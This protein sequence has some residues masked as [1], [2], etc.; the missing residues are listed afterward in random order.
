MSTTR[1][2]DT[3]DWASGGIILEPPVAKQGVGWEL[4]EFPPFNFVNWFWNRS[5]IWVQHFASVASR[6]ETIEGAIE[7]GPASPF[8]LDG[9]CLVKG[10][11]AFTPGSVHTVDVTNLGAAAQVIAA[12]G[13][14]VVMQPGDP[15]GGAV[16]ADVRSFRRDGS[17]TVIA[18]YQIAATATVRILADGVHVAYPQNNDLHVY[19]HD[20]GANL[21][22]QALGGGTI[23]DIAWDDGFI[24]VVGTFGGAQI[25]K[26]NR[27]TGVT[28]W[29][30][31]H[32]AALESVAVYGDRVF[33]AGVASAHASGATIRSV[34]ASDGFDTTGEGGNGTD[35]NQWNAVQG[36]LT[37]LPRML[38]VDGRGLYVGAGAAV[39][40]RSPAGGEVINTISAPFGNDIRSIKIDHARLFAATSDRVFPVGSGALHVFDRDTLAQVWRYLQV[41]N[42]RVHDIATDGDA[43]FVAQIIGNNVVPRLYRGT[44]TSWW[45]RVDPSSAS[46]RTVGALRQLLIPIS[47]T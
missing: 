14:S 21:F 4:R 37:T 35:N 10:D 41:G 7:I 11:E 16:A 32:N 23:N 5:A 3:P 19:D 9:T 31:D 12:T 17:G 15:D 38:A 6:F 47:R 2:T 33:V 44:R 36:T 42:D 26:I 43:V 22:I 8:A 20:T 39:E 25:K 27:L 24:Y 40:V 30:F 29:A 34:R 28:V 13:R 1:P 46:Y 45:Q 18:T